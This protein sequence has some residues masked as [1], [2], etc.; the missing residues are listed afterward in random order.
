[1]TSDVAIMVANDVLPG[2]RMPLKLENGNIYPKRSKLMKTNYTPVSKLMK[3]THNVSS[4][5]KYRS[6]DRA[7][8]VSTE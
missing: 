7:S 8:N 5:S 4:F 1:M 2:T 3:T 6:P